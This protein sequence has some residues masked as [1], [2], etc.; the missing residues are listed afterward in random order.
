MKAKPRDG[1]FSQLLKWIGYATAILSFCGTLYGLGKLVYDRAD[2]RRKI[3]ALLSAEA[4]Q[5][6]GRDYDSAW[7]TLEQAAKLKPD[8]P[9]V[10]EAQKSLAILWLDDIALE[11]T[12]KFSAITDK[13]VPVL[14]REIAASKPGVSRADLLAYLGWAYYLRFRE[15]TSEVDPAV[16]FGEAIREDAN[17]PYAHS[18]WGYVLLWSRRS[19]DQLA[20]ANEHFASALASGR[21]QDFVRLRQTLALADCGTDECLEELLRVASAMRQE[22][23][24]LTEHPM[25]RLFNN[26]YFEFGGGSQ[27]SESFLHAIP[28]AEHLATFHWAF[29]NVQMDEAKSDERTFYTA[30]LEEAAGEREAAIRNYRLCVEHGRPHSGSMWEAANAALKRLSR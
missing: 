18:M 17:N 27:H 9:R 13:L 15:E 7:G 2:T 20:R 16:T 29:D 26:Y 24:P 5:L 14:S 21:Q 8:S 25:L 4:V 6:T 11:R 12:Q 19:S 3:D 1:K 28:P 10:R 22:Q 30:V 23:R